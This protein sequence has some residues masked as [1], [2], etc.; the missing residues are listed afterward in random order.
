MLP[1]QGPPPK[2]PSS[3]LKIIGIIAAILPGSPPSAESSTSDHSSGTEGTERPSSQRV[4]NDF[5]VGDCFSQPGKTKFDPDFPR[6]N[7][8]DCDDSNALLQA[9]SIKKKPSD[10]SCI[11]TAGGVT[12]LLSPDGSLLC[13][14][15][16]NVDPD[17]TIYLARIGDCAPSPTHPG[18]RVS[19]AMHVKA[20]LVLHVPAQ[21]HLSRDGS[22]HRADEN[23]ERRS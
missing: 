14:G 15:E 11:D 13:L 17:T 5:A 8:T 20:R 16:K 7:L 23:H 2:K 19:G 21:R 22:N 18:S 1:P 10:K 4:A 3:A 9:I 6:V 12:T